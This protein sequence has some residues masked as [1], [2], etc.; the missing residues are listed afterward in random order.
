MHELRLRLMAGAVLAAALTLSPLHMD[1]TIGAQPALADDDDSDDDGGGGGGDDDDDN[2]NSGP[3]DS[4]G[5]SDDSDDDDDDDDSS[6]SGGNSGPGSSCDDDG[7][8]EEDES[9]DDDDDEDDDDEDDDDDDEDEDELEAGGGDDGGGDGGDGDNGRDDGER[10]DYISGEVLVASSD[11]SFLQVV[12]GL[13]YR[14]LEV[15]RFQRLGLDVVRLRTPPGLA[16][17]RAR[18]DL[19]GRFPGLTFDVNGLFGLQQGLSL[20][21]PGT[22]QSMLAWPTVCQAG[23]TVGL[24]DTAVDV[25]ALP[26]GS[27]VVH[28]PAGAPPGAHG[29]A[30][31]SLMLGS[32]QAGVPSLIGGGRL[33]VAAIVD[34]AR[35]ARTSAL[36]LVGGLDWLVGQRARVINISLAGEPSRILDLA[37]DG[38]V[39]AGTVIVAAAGNGGPSALPVWPAAHPAVIAVT[40]LDADRSIYPDA[41]RGAHIDLAAPGVGLRVASPG[42]A[43]SIASGTSFA[44]PMVSAAAAVALGMGAPPATVRERLTATALD[45]GAAGPDSVFGAGLVQ[46]PPGC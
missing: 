4:S 6:G 12:Q 33:A 3:S 23:L 34:E 16:P 1:F 19:A 43:G 27:S 9:D 35:P 42:G 24:I 5:G 11:A 36:D 41:G 46:R 45:L 26:P 25:T 8:D 29:T 7:E 17:V 2:D 13:G 21:P 37:I 28:A 40:A 30:V 44:A 20:T 32:P 15:E 39:G 18:N 14:V 38:T 10:R 31:A 22:V